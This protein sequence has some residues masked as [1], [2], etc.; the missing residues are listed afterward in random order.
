MKRKS[1][2][3]TETPRERVLSLLDKGERL[4]EQSI[5]L[6]GLADAAMSVADALVQSSRERR[7][8]AALLRR[9]QPLPSRPGSSKA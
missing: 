3:S 5:E 9:K 7:A 1:P 6:M 8:A 4:R 2:D